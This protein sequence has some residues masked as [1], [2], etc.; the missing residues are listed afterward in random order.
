[1]IGILTIHTGYNEGAVLQSLALSRLLAQVTGEQVEVLDHRY[2]AAL[3]KSE[4]P[5]DTPRKQAIAAFR[6]THLP[7]S[8]K[9]FEDDRTGAWAYAA[10][11]YG[12]IVVGSDEV[13]KVVYRK[14]LKGLFTVQDDPLA[15]AYPNVWWPDASAGQVRIAYAATAGART[16]WRLVPRRHRAMM[17]EA[18][19]GFHALGLRDE[20]TRVFIESVA[21]QAAARSVRVPDPTLAY[22]LLAEAGRDMRPRLAAL[23]VDFTRPRVAFVASASKVASGLAARLE[24]AGVQTVAIS[25]PLPGTGLD[26]SGAPF[27]PLDWAA[28][29]G[30]FDL[31]VSDRMHGCIFTLRNGTPLLVLDD[32]RR[33]LGFPTKNE[34]IAKRFELDDFYF[35]IIRPETTVDA[36]EAAARRALEGDW[37]FAAVAARITAEHDIARNF[38]ATAFERPAH[39]AS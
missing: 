5:A 38:L 6:D 30:C 35:P 9:R 29:F 16:D 37:P 34:E 19:S 22:D 12:A 3:R 20:R 25:R 31:V 11:R 21:P 14:R 18:V 28:T 15:P 17:A 1:M 10:Q 2:A 7:L 32:R 33:T 8:P 24:A 23:G 26:L 36:L 4:G 13:W 27:D 39:A